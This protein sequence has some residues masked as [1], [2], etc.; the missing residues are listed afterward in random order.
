MFGAGWRI[1]DRDVSSHGYDRPRDSVFPKRRQSAIG[2]EPFCDAA[3]IQPHSRD[4]QTD[5]TRLGIQNNLA[6]AAKRERAPEFGLLGQAI[7]SPGPAPN[8]IDRSRCDVES[9]IGFR[10]QL[11]SRAEDLKQVL[12]D[13]RRLLIGDA[14]ETR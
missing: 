4:L 1:A 2:R 8:P 14:A 10:G 11:E 9:A 13:R 3:E 7:L 5:R 12:A 6:G